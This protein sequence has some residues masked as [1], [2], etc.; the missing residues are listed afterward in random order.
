MCV[1]KFL[2][3]VRRRS[4]SYPG[5]TCVRERFSIF[6]LVASEECKPGVGTDPGSRYISATAHALFYGESGNRPSLRCGSARF[7]LHQLH[8][9]QRESVNTLRLGP[10]ASMP[11]PLGHFFYVLL[12]VFPLSLGHALPVRRFEPLVPLRTG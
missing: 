2:S 9:G 1:Q 11:L 10:I 4:V 12:P 3:R 6:V 5:V 7:H 8:M